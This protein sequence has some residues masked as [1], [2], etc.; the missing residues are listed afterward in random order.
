V[1]CKY[2]KA[3]VES[4]LDYHTQWANCAE[5]LRKE[6]DG[7]YKAA[8]YAQGRVDELLK[9]NEKLAQTLE[10]AQGQLKAS[11]HVQLDQQR[12]IERL[13]ASV[14][15]GE[16]LYAQATKNLKD[17]LLQLRVAQGV[18]LSAFEVGQLQPHAEDASCPGDDTCD[19]LWAARINEAT[20][21]YIP[22]NEETAAAS[23]IEDRI[24]GVIETRNDPYRQPKGKDILGS[25]P[26]FPVEGQ[27]GDVCGPCGVAHPVADGQAERCGLHRPG[28]VPVIRCILNRAHP[29]P[30]QYPEKRKDRCAVCHEHD[31]LKT[32][33]CKPS[34]R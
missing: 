11:L 7:N 22:T 5:A 34:L 4:G 30:C 10:S 14:Y 13:K 3:P 29:G 1:D 20:K 33:V 24:L 27:P 26:D 19:C 6:A 18:I 23:K 32:H 17:A 12:E 28:V 2:C 15:A 9:A 16:D 8:K 25:L 31:D 21:G